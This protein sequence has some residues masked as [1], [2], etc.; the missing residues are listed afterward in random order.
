[1]KSLLA[2]VALLVAASSASAEEPAGTLKTIQQSKVIKLGYQEDSVPFAFIDEN[3]QPAG[4]S[5]ELCKRV[6]AGIQQQLG[7]ANLE[8]KWVPVNLE[9]R[10]D[11]IRD[12]SIDLECGIST[13]TLS[14]QKLVDFS[15]T[16]WVD[17]ASFFVNP[18]VSGARKLSDLNGKRIGVIPGTTTERAISD[19]AKRDYL[20]IQLVPVKDH[21]EGIAALKAGKVDAYSSDQAVLIGLAFAM[22]DQFRVLI[23]EQPFSYE[24]YGLVMRRGDPD[25]RLAVNTVVAR[26]MRTGQVLGIY[27]HWFG[28]LGKPSP[29]LAATWATNGLPPADTAGTQPAQPGWVSRGCA[30]AANARIRAGGD[31]EEDCRQQE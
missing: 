24:P 18:A 14:R 7:L 12:G 2:L 20:S 25:F 9:N 15:L 10:F 5:V 8:I 27:E 28:K 31:G 3:K 4:Y 11:K 23:C 1:V 30:P 13:N 17:G 22:R 16:T 29:L 26:I 21:I 6:A 19:I